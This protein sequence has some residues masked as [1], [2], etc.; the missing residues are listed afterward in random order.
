MSE[1]VSDFVLDTS[2]VITYLLDESGSNAV[3]DILVDAQRKQCR[4]HLSFVTLTEIY[5]TSL[6]R[7]SPV[8]AR[9]LIVHVKALPVA[10]VHSDERLSLVAGRLKAF[11][12]IS[13]A[14]AFIAATAMEKKARL[15]HKDPEFESL[16]EFVD[17]LSLPYK[18]SV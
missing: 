5:Y 8:V 14:D 2:A 4:V 10:I 18:K 17:L 1:K 13:L 15:V 9:E 3:R 6:Q 16:I 12:H 7:Q 11:H